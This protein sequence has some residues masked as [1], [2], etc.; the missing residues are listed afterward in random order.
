MGAEDDS[1][2]PQESPAYYM[3]I[4]VNLC[5]FV[6][7][8]KGKAGGIPSCRH[9]SHGLVNLEYFKGDWRVHQE[10]FNI[11]FRF[12]F[13]PRSTLELASRYYRQLI[14]VFGKADRFLKPCWPQLWQELEIFRVSGL[15]ET[16][17]LVPRDDYGSVK[18]TLD[19]YLA[20]YRC[21]Q[22]HWEINWKSEIAPEFRLLPPKE[23]RK[24]TPIQLLAV[25]RALRYNDY[26]NALSFRDVDLSILWNLQDSH[27]GKA[28]VAYLS[29]TL[30][31][32]DPEEAE[33]LQLSPLL[34]QEFHALAF[35]SETIRQ[36]DLRNTSA[37][38]LSRADSSRQT[39]PSL[40]YVAPILNLI[41]A[42]TTRCTRLILSHNTL[43]R[44]DILEITEAL[45]TGTIQALDISYCG[46]DDMDMQ[47]M[48]LIPLEESP[49]AL[50]SLNL[51]GNPGRI[52]VRSLPTMLTHLHHLRRLC[53]CGSLQGQSTAP[54]L[55]LETLEQLEFLEEL[56]LS[57]FKLNSASLRVLEQFLHFRG[58]RLDNK[59]PFNFR[60]L[61]LNNCG[62]TG[63]Q[64]AGLFNAVGVDHGLDM[65][66]SGNPLE[67][68]I[69]DLAGAILQN[70][71]PARLTMDM[72]EFRE[73]ANYCLLIRVL[74]DTK[75]LRHL[76]LVGTVPVPSM[77][78]TCSSEIVRVLENFLV[79]NTSLRSLDL[80]GY[81]GRLDDGQLAK[82][83][84]RALLG[85]VRNR[86]LRSFKVR[87]QNL[88]DDAGILG[89]V[90]AGNRGLVSFDCQDNGLNLSTLKFLVSSL[91]ENKK[92]VDFPFDE[93][94]RA[95]IWAGIAAGLRK[96]SATYAATSAAAAAA[97]AASF[98]SGR[99]SASRPVSG[100]GGGGGKE[101]KK[102]TSKVEAL[103]SEMLRDQEKMLKEV[104]RKQ[105]DTLDEYLR[106]NRLASPLQAE[107][108]AGFGGLEFVDEIIASSSSSS[109]NEADERADVGVAVTTTGDGAERVAAAS[110][111]GGDRVRR[112]RRATV[113]SSNIPA[114]ASQVLVG[115][116]PPSISISE[117][118]PVPS[119]PY[120]FQTRQEQDGTGTS[121]PAETLE[122]EEEEDGFEFGNMMEEFKRAGLV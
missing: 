80:S 88:H 119:V 120:H 50:Q 106:R 24:Y 92:I 32:L 23:G 87:N 109:D 9:T 55:P 96:S 7:I 117:E 90:V 30:V 43:P 82:G 14:L 46:L 8:K 64:A 11:T 56:D 48:I 72:V 42:G 3:I 110:S 100:T 114:G 94:E 6:T 63:R 118:V 97:A 13:K 70:T 37:S 91:K 49:Q 40:Q 12:P 45:K 93:A 27:V 95:A 102:G 4:G 19:A 62:I 47:D 39:R 18:R 83:F 71:L 34:H 89:Q 57:S 22:V 58:D 77:R 59:Q 1:K 115:V 53:L 54:L 15:G 116:V 122:N 61:S 104:L 65:S 81:C 29:R 85:L 17:Y 99:Y 31:T 52:T 84:A 73:E 10:R 107:A 112:L 79:H 67:E 66:L 35:C 5:H 2:K 98:A 44:D 16:Q 75:H 103:R 113:R 101:A 69:E 74:T 121:S 51:S 36:I 78:G 38:F 20:A 60:K 111:G 105:F 33:I 25:L 21:E 86:T 28:N 76:S 41:K 26:F 68:G 108:W